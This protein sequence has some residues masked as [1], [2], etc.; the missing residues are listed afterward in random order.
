MK[1]LLIALAFIAALLV[2]A[3]GRAQERVTIDVN[4][5]GGGFISA[6]DYPKETT[7][8]SG[9]TYDTNGIGIATKVAVTD[10]VSVEG[11]Y[12][13]VGLRNAQFFTE[14][15]SSHGGRRGIM[16][17]QTEPDQQAVGG[18]VGYWEL[19]G[20]FKLPKTHGHSLLAGIANTK[21]DRD[22]LSSEVGDG[23]F[24]YAL[25][26]SHIGFVL[27]GG[28]KQR[29]GNITFDYS[30]RLYPRMSRKDSESSDGMS[31]PSPDSSSFGYEVRATATWMIA[32]H[33]GLTGGYEFRRLRTNESPN[34]S[35]PINENQDS[36]LVLVGLRI[37]F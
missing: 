23:T 30:T 28:G 32:K 6:F 29:V 33:I 18:V 22:F 26:A 1:S 5:V 21:L 19:S 8:S 27:G 36:K 15:R 35:W 4:D 12:E 16:G 14:D 2:P 10:I 25:H 20:S 24:S 13:H 7:L 37:G 11:R 34:S 3:L 31:W 9:K 17:R